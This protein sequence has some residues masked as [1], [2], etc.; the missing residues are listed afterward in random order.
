MTKDES[1]LRWGIPG[2]VSIIS[3]TMFAL[4]DY[5]ASNDSTIYVLI[6][7]ALK[8]QE[9]WRT[10]VAALLIAAAGIPLGFLYF[11]IYFY[12]RW[13]SPVSKSGL[14]PPLIVGRAE[15]LR[16]MLRDIQDED[17]ELGTPWRDRLLSSST[18]HRGSWHYISQFLAEVFS[19]QNSSQ[20][21]SDKHRYLLTTLHSLGASHIG[22]S[23]GFIFYLLTKWKL[24]QVN[25]IWIPIA[26]LIVFVTLA[27]LSKSDYPLHKQE[28]IHKLAVRHSAEVFLAS[29]F[30]VYFTLNPFFDQYIS[31]AVPLLIC[32]SQGIYWGIVEKDSREG[33]WF[34]TLLLIVGTLIL[35]LTGLSAQIS[36]MNWSIFL[37]TLIFSSMSLAFL[38]NRQN[39]RDALGTLEY[40]E[41][42]RFLEKHSS[43]INQPSVQSEKTSFLPPQ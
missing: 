41:I 14:L 36:W 39:T 10:L 7:S 33:I 18:D 43:R 40:Y 2:W 22:F 25:I 11:Q 37:S 26:F 15:E 9:L 8:E 32:T 27:L 23:F 34:I 28:P 13:N 19:T 29:L 3:F 1:V 20:T 12:L 16:L 17:L 6:N 31:F 30:F 21:I 4:I 24:Q 35:R 42:R 38:K 5:F